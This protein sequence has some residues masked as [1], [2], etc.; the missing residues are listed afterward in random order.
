MS[1][2]LNR[3]RKKNVCKTCSG[4]RFQWFM[5][6]STRVPTNTNRTHNMLYAFA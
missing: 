2:H 6:G 4:L 1:E 3:Q 5:D